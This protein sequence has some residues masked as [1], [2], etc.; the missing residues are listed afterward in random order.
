MPNVVTS[1]DKH[2]ANIS[3]FINNQRDILQLGDLMVYWWWFWECFCEDIHYSCR[4]PR[5]RASIAVVGSCGTSS[6][7]TSRIT[8]GFVQSIQREGRQDKGQCNIFIIASK[9][10]R[11][12]FRSCYDIFR[13]KRNFCP[14]QV[15]AKIIQHNCFATINLILY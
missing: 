8:R 7:K 11:N 10:G 6:K 14:R 12:F 15:N 1:L 5:R 9:L 3:G 4:K 13:V 2:I